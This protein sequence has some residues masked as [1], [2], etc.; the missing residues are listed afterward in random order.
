M[1]PDADRLERL[2]RLHREEDLGVRELAVE[3]FSDLGL[4][5]C[6]FDG[7]DLARGKAGFGQT[8][9]PID[10]VAWNVH[11]TAPLCAAAGAL[12]GG[13]PHDNEELPALVDH[14]SFFNDGVVPGD[15]PDLLS[16]FL[17]LVFRHGNL[18]MGQGG[19]VSKAAI[20]FSDAEVR[21]NPVEDL[22]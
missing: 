18:L 20:L 11:K 5:L 2:W 14:P 4:F 7:F 3:H 13:D 21:E 12:D 19:V 22:L 10:N 6:V 8:V 15:K 1:D 17:V 16:R 9:F